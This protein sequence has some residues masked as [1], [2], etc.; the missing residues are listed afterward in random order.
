MILDAAAV[1]AEQLRELIRHHN[2]RYYV[3]DD[4]EV[5][6]LQYD[7]LLEEM[8]ELEAARPDLVTPDSPTQRVG[9]DVHT[10]FGSVAHRVP[11]LSLDN[12]FGEEPLLAWEER[13]C[14]HL[15]FRAGTALAYVAELKIDGASISLTYENGVLARGLTRGNGEVG[16]DITPNIRTIGAIP[17]RLRA[18]D[19]SPPGIIEVRGELFLT[20]KE[21]AR[22][23]A[24]LEES[25]DRTFANPRNAAAGSLRQKDPR[26]T[27]SRRLNAFFYTLGYIRNHGP[28][29]QWELL[30]TYRSWGLRTNPNVRLCNGLKEVLEFCAEWGEKRR[31]LDYDIDGVVV[32]INDFDLQRELGSVSRSPRWAI[33]YKGYTPNQARTRVNDI[34]IQVGRLG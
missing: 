26:I 31:T 19:H 11:M 29:S 13:N 16:E 12:A 2:Y 24:A 33:A 4:P 30:Q 9:A 6:D 14:R 20:H 21:F 27:A 10:S 7:A 32:K 1:R 18:S 3:L 17:L 28:A 8:R 34:R 15:G 25:G 22:I 5:S 23:N